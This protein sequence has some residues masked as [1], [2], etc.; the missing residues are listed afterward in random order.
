MAKAEELQPGALEGIVAGIVADRA[1]QEMKR[2]GVTAASDMAETR[3]IVESLSKSQQVEAI[4]WRCKHDPWFFK[5][6]LIYTIDELDKETSVKRIPAWPHLPH[7]TK[8]IAQHDMILIEKARHV[9]ATWSVLG[10]ILHDALFHDH[11]RSFVQCMKGEDACEHISM[12][13]ARSQRF[14]R[15]RIRAMYDHLPPGWFSGAEW[16]Q[17]EVSFENHSVI[18]A[19]PG[20]A[21][22]V[23]EYTVSMYFSDEAAYTDEFEDTWTAAK[24]SVEGGG[25]LIA[26][27]TPNHKEAF[28]Y[29]F[30][31]FRGTGLVHEPVPGMRVE[32][33]ANG[34][35]LVTLNWWVVPGHDVAWYAKATAGLSPAKARQEYDIDYG[36]FEGMPVY[37]QFRRE[38]HIKKLEYRPDI[39]VVRGWDF[40]YRRAVCVFAQVVGRDLHILGGVST[41]QESTKMLAMAVVQ[42]S[43]D[44]FGPDAEYD[45]VGDPAGSGDRGASEI[46]S[47]EI[48]EN[49]P[50]NIS[51]R[52]S[53]TGIMDG[54]DK[55]SK[56]LQENRFRVNAAVECEIIVDALAGGYSF[57]KTGDL[58]KK[59]GIHDHWMDAVRYIVE[60]SF[61][62][63]DDELP[64]IPLTEEQIIDRA[65]KAV[66]T[67]SRE[68]RRQYEE[69]A[70]PFTRNSRG[71]R[72]QEPKRKTR[73]KG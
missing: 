17:G 41:K 68:Q 7:L 20:G 2:V 21:G 56:L 43:H 71:V 65:T 63:A 27:T 45:D 48:L 1:E 69:Y 55:V 64:P 42:A 58:P 70:R 11:R 9:F 30:K 36:V 47:M 35:A 6:K 49:H 10:D 22:Q 50:F 59:D 15:G 8:V 53:K 66:F 62:A 14:G 33:C 67:R 52:W 24:P 19:L 26:V 32:E 73:R 72:R 38:A 44:L 13:T 3:K 51:L 37:P 18:K 5:Q 40:G 28:Y 57:N 29:L 39:P 54:V 46:T 25:K 23:R 60:N 34:M 31:E 61:D 16:Y 4:R 12:R